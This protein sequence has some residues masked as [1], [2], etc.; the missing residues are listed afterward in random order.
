MERTPTARTEV[1]LAQGQE[2]A[3]SFSIFVTVHLYHV[4]VMPEAPGLVTET[5]R[6]A[7]KKV[8]RACRQMLVCYET[9]VASS[10]HGFPWN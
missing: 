6:F 2:G 3:T 4:A 10:L 9:F 7:R 8:P 1:D 5:Q